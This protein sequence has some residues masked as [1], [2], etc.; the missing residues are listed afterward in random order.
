LLARLIDTPPL[1]AVREK[2]Y[3]LTTLLKEAG[4]IAAAEGRTAESRMCYLKG[5]QLLLDSLA[6]GDAFEQPEFVPKVDLFVAALDEIPTQTSAL[7]M[8]HY[9]RTGQFGKA[10][11]ALYTILDGD[12]DNDLAVNFGISFYERLLGQ[13]DTLLNEGN[14][15]RAEVEA[16]LQDLRDRKVKV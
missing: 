7:L 3:F 14:L 11:D 16:G 8:E 12:V 13:S 10:E 9:E 15:P 1:Q 5:L 6:R 4:D 2:M